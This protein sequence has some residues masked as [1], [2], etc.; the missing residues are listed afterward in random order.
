[1]KEFKLPTQNIIKCTEG[2]YSGPSPKTL[3]EFGSDRIMFRKI[4]EWSPI[5]G[6]YGM[7]GPGFFG[8]KLSQK[9]P[10][11]E[12]WLVLRLWAAFFW[13]LFDG[14]WLAAPS[15]QHS[16]QR[17]LYHGTFEGWDDFTNLIIGL[18]IVEAIIK[19]DES[20]IYLEGNSGK[21]I[22]EIPKD[23]KRLS[24]YPIPMAYHQW[25]ESESQLDAWVITESAKL[26]V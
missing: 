23:T 16:E 7:G 17:P 20:L 26:Y 14:Q 25:F 1:M 2:S 3:R 8:L 4:T 24:K 12:E 13:L 9:Q 19:D 6:S 22:L 15:N 18:A 11:P 5:I 21:H 10:F